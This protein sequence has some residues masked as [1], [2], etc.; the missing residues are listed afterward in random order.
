MRTILLLVC[1]AV[2]GIAFVVSCDHMGAGGP[3]NAQS[4]CGQW[5][6]Q[7][8]SA[9]S[10]VPAGWEPFAATADAQSSTAWLR[11]CKP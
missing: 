5:E 9:S 8:Q 7:L 11:R 4:S 1:G 3:A 2:A 10:A 6:I